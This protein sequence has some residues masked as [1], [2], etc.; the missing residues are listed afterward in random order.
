MVL[1]KLLNCLLPALPFQ[2][3]YQ[4]LLLYE[5]QNN[6]LTFSFVL[7]L[8]FLIILFKCLRIIHANL[9]YNA[10]RTYQQ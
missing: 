6:M 10:G 1:E 3:C 5:P 9:R 2:H 4:S 7:D 8:L